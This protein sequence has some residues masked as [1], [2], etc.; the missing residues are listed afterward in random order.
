VPAGI[1]IGERRQQQRAG[2]GAHVQ[3]V[4]DQGDRAEQQAADDLRDHHGA[5]EPDYRPGLALAGLVALAEEYVA[6]ER[7]S[8]DAVTLNHGSPHLADAAHHP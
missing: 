7:R 8:S 5:A 6:V 3:A 2:V 4:G 1:G